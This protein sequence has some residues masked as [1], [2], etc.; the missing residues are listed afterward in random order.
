[1]PGPPGLDTDTCRSG[2]DVLS[3]EAWAL[4][5]WGDA[6]GTGSGGYRLL[7]FVFGPIILG[8]TEL[9]LVWAQFFS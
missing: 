5:G 3:V 8:L 9:N 7:G 4:K 1:M 2:R 6:A